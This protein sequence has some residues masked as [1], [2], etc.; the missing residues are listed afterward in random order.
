MISKVINVSLVVVYTI[1]VKFLLG[2]FLLG[3][4]IKYVID[5]PYWIIQIMETAGLYSPR[6]ASEA[7]EKMSKLIGYGF[8]RNNI[9]MKKKFM[10]ACELLPKLPY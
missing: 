8:G 9:E 10:H 2:P 7:S 3:P 5:S 4:L 6:V 1:L